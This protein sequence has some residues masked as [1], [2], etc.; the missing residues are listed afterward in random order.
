MDLHNEIMNIPTRV[1]TYN[2]EY[3]YE[4]G[5]SDA[6]HTAAEFALKAQ[7]RIAELEESLE[8]VLDRFKSVLSSTPVKDADEVICHLEKL[9]RDK[10]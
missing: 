1:G 3:C 6:R 9:L 8:W 10:E 7:A 2:D 4:L 5:H